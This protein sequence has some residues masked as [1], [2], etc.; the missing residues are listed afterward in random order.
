MPRLSPL[1]A[2]ARA[3]DKPNVVFILAGDKSVRKE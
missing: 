2:L 1:A 3:A